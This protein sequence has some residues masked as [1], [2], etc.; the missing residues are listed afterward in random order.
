M[1]RAHF[2]NCGNVSRYCKGR[3]FSTNADAGGGEN[4]SFG[5]KVYTMIR[6]KVN[7]Y[8]ILRAA[9]VAV[10]G[11]ALYQTGYQSGLITY[12][13][14]PHKIEKEMMKGVIAAAGAE[15]YHPVYHPHHMQVKRVSERI[16]FAAKDMYKEKLE[17]LVA[18]NM[19]LEKDLL[20]NNEKTPK[21]NIDSAQVRHSNFPLRDKFEKNKESIELYSTALNHMKGS[22]HYVVIA[23]PTINA[24]VTAAC[25]RR[26]FV[27][28]GLIEKLQPTDDELAIILGHEISHFILEHVEKEQ[29]YNATL[30]ILQLILL[31]FVEPLGLLSVF[32][33]QLL[34][35]VSTFLDA[36]YSRECEEE[37]DTLGIELAARAC[38]DTS[39]SAKIF[40]KLANATMNPTSSSSSDPLVEETELI[41]HKSVG[42][43]DTHPSWDSRIE[44]VT[45]LSRDHNSERYRTCQ[46]YLKYYMDSIASSFSK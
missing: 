37:A 7:G 17:K 41:S 34:S 36:S 2:R 6:S 1:F 42:W 11:Y 24:F 21:T 10:L 3:R 14:D 40:L 35:T 33:D 22:W 13:Q 20:A 9:R 26:V 23:V 29:S 8:Q 19:Q 16:V 46:S 44:N 15:S 32:Y 45:T 31:T 18:E 43:N 25:P 12:A 30:K 27:H 4:V 5:K 38:Y 39:K 28:S